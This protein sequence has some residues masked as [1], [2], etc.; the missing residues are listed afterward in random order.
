MSVKP[1]R[2]LAQ[3]IIW[4]IIA[5]LTTFIIGWVVTGGINF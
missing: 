4:R 5:S 1:R 3:A 2:H